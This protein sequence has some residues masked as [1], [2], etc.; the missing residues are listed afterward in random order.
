[1]NN[2]TLR[3]YRPE[4]EN[5]YRETRKSGNPTQPGNRSTTSRPAKKRKRKTI[6]R[7]AARFYKRLNWKGRLLLGALIVLAL[8]LLFPFVTNNGNSEAEPLPVTTEAADKQLE[9]PEYIFRDGDGHPVDWEGLTNAWA[10]E[11]GFEKRYTLTDA[12]RWE[13]ASVI[14]AEAEGEPFAGKVAVAQIQRIEEKVAAAERRCENG[15]RFLTGKLAEYFET[16]PHKKT[17]TKESYRLLSGS[18]T[19][20]LGGTQMKQDDEKLLEYL[21][22]SGNED[23]IKVTEKP[24][25]GEFKKRLVIMGGAGS[26]SRHRRD[27]GRRGNH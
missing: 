18:L 2:S 8:V 3:V 6:L 7:R 1:M 14:T 5:T 13:I 19:K 16:V 22:A 12:E 20:K 24:A 4:G 10:A 27:S 15:T 25:W 26:R 17:K 11:A 9:Q 21:K 23:M